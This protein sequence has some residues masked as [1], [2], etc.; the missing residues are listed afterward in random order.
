MYDYIPV[1]INTNIKDNL[2]FTEWENILYSITDNSNSI[3]FFG[4]KPSDIFIKNFISKI[5][6]FKKL[7]KDLDNRRS[8]LFCD[9]ISLI[10]IDDTNNKIEDKY[11]R[12][13]SDKLYRIRK[14]KNNNFD[15]EEIKPI[16]IT[17]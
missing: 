17:K 14:W 4:L 15:R 7:N 6:E 8:E 16:T 11:Q 3:R 10:E 13:E 9:S 2:N 12:Y 5:D 1:I